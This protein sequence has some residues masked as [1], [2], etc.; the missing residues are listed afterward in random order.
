MRCSDC[1]Q[2]FSLGGDSSAP[3]VFLVAGGIAATI[4][5]ALFIASD[6][7]AAQVWASIQAYPSRLPRRGAAGA[8]LS[9]LA[10]AA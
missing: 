3:G 4:G 10:V 8:W 5:V 1:G 2:H 7:F 6:S 9:W